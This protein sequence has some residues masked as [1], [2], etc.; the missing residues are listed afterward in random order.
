LGNGGAVDLDE[1]A[2]R[3]LAVVVDGVGDELLAGAVLALDQDVG[4]ARRHALDQLEELLHL[5]AAA[6]DVGELVLVLQLLLQLDVL[7]LQL[8]ALDRLLEQGQHAFGVDRLLQEVGRPGLDRLDRPA[9]CCPARSRR[10][11]P[12]SGCCP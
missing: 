5:L 2:L 4:L 12:R 10:G 3:P 9:G 8:G 7:G 1:R 6:D 11:L